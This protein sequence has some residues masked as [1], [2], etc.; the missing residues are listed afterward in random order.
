M[1]VLFFFLMMLLVFIY[2]LYSI[3]LMDFI[4]LKRDLITLLTGV[5][6]PNLWQIGLLRR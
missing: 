5:D 1:C 4:L 3:V 2:V 6:G